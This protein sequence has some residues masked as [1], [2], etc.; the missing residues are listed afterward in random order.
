MLVFYVCMLISIYGLIMH[1]GH[2]WILLCTSFNEVKKAFTDLFGNLVHLSIFIRIIIHANKPKLIE[3]TKHIFRVKCVS[4]NFFFYCLHSL[5]RQGLSYSLFTKTFCQK[6]WIWCQ[7]KLVT[8]KNLA[9][10]IVIYQKL[11]KLKNTKSFYFLW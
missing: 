6:S 7:I 5:N 10:L 2:V 11:I 9:L 8:M 4:I 3:N 1:M